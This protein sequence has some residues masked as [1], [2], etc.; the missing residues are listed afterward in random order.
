MVQVPWSM[1]GA[2]YGDVT[3]GP[4]AMYGDVTHGPGACMIQV[5]CMEM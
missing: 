2:M 5:P 3:H 1:Y 4:G